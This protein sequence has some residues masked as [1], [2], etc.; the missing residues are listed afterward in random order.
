[1]R[2]FELLAAKNILM[3]W[4]AKKQKP[5][6][7]CEL[8]SDCI[9]VL[10]LHIRQGD[11][12]RERSCDD[13]LSLGHE[14]TP[15]TETRRYIIIIRINGGANGIHDHTRRRHRNS[16]RNHRREQYRRDQRHQ[17]HPME[18]SVSLARFRT[19]STGSGETPTE[20]T[21]SAAGSGATSAFS[22][23]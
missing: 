18:F 16:T 10:Y 13:S 15:R 8:I 20:F 6:S 5:M 3:H 9:E 22:D 21:E 4:T 7:F 19:P 2:D 11:L 12:T 23:L 17:R 1:L 14:V